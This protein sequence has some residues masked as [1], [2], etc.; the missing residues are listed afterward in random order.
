MNQKRFG[1]WAQVIGN[2][3]VVAGI[4]L[5]IYELKQNKELATAQLL[6]TN[7]G[8]V[9]ERNIATMGENPQT[10][11]FKAE[12]CADML[13]GEEAVTLSKHYTTWVV[14][15]FKYRQTAML[16]NVELDWRELVK[17]QI[18]TRFVSP[19]SRRWLKAFIE[20]KAP[21]MSDDL[22]E[23]AVAALAEAPAATFDKDLYMAILAES[24]QPAV[25]LASPNL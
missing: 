15:W 13:T 22:R 16:A 25:C 4:V 2:L 21:V 7:M 12:F 5:I 19:V 14:G 20:S 23:V 11:L 24:P 1:I 9:E 3:A 10:A 6:L 17:T 18:R 8:P